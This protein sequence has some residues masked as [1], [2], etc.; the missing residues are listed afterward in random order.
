MKNLP[1]LRR[2]L[3]PTSLCC[4][5]TALAFAVS[6]CDHPKDGGKKSAEDNAAEEAVALKNE[7]DRLQ[8]DIA[9]KKAELEKLEGRL[10]IANLPKDIEEVNNQIKVLENAKN[11]IKKVLG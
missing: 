2:K 1:A 9:R 5:L 6:S 3:L 11:S 10:Y 8:E 7:S 4:F